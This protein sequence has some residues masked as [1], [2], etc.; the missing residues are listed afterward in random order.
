[1]LMVKGCKLVSNVD[2]DPKTG[3]MTTTHYDFPSGKVS[4]VEVTDIPKDHKQNAAILKAKQNQQN[5][6]ATKQPNL[7][8][9]KKPARKQHVGK[10]AARPADK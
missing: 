10:Q 9:K 1:M 3:K 8:G 6:N 7:V 5:L 4:S 2:T